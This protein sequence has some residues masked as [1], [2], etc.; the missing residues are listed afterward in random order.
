MLLRVGDLEMSFECHFTAAC[1]QGLLVRIPERIVVRLLRSLEGARLHGVVNLHPA[2]SSILI[3][4]DSL[5]TSHSEIECRVREMAARLEEFAE[6]PARLVEIPGRFDGP[7]LA[8][9]AELC[10]LTASEYSER[11]ASGLYTVYFL[12][13]V[14][15]FAYMGKLAEEIVVPRLATP[16]KSVPAG[17]VAVAN[18]QTAV[19]P[20]ATPGGW[21]LIGRT[22][23]KL[24]DPSLAGLSLLHAGDQVRFVPIR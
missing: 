23:V 22:E 16:R 8:D 10:K 1:D 6:A 5:V 7:D 15:G 18:D 4:F 13:F 3:R 9:C 17:S 20:I 12:G 24:F 19:Y 14:P 11:H 21:R 2:Y